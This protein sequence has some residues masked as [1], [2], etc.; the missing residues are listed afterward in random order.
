[1]KTDKEYFDFAK[2]VIQNTEPIDSATKVQSLIETIQWADR[3]YYVEDNPMLSDTEYDLLFAKLKLTEGE[4]PQWQFSYSPSQNVAD[5]LNDDFEK[6]NHLQPM[7]SLDNSYNDEDLRDWNERIKKILGDQKFEFTVEPKFDGASISA[8]ISEHSIE[9]VL[10]RGNGT[11]GDDITRNARQIKSLPQYV[12]Y[13]ENLAQAEVRGEV[14]MKW[15]DFDNYNAYLESEGK[16]PMVNPRNAASGSLRMKDPMELQKRRLSAFMYHVSYFRPEN[17]RPYDTHLGALKWL[18]KLG[19]QTALKYTGQC[20]D[21]EGVIQYCLDFEAKRDDMGFEIDGMVVKVNSL[22][23]QEELGS[24]A[25]HPRWAMAYKFKAKQATTKLERVEYQVG[26][27]GAITPVAKIEPVFVGGVTISSVSLFNEDTI[28]DKD[29]KLGDV[30]VVERSGDVI[31]Y[32]RKSLP[33]LR[34]GAEKEIEFPAA[35]PVCET[36]LIKEDEDVAWR[37]PNY[38]CPAQNEERLIHFVS[39]NAMDIK[40]MGE[41]HV[42][43]FYQMGMIRK[44]EDIYTMDLEVLR[45]EEGYG[46][47]TIENLRTAIEESKNRA[48]NRVLFALGV[49]HV[50]QTTAK[51]IVQQLD[52]SLWEIERWSIEELESIEDIGPKVAKSIYEYF[53][54]ASAK[55]T[56][57]SLERSGV[58]LEIQKQKEISNS[59]LNGKTFLFTGAMQMK[60]AEAEEMAEAKGGKILSG[61]SSKLDY[62][63]VGEK[64]GSKLAKAEKLGT[65]NILTEDEFLELI[66]TNEA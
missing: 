3:K 24:T 17:E 59:A 63:V 58:N 60:R 13:E 21:I 25:H 49:R 40:S 27:T 37:C 33:E 2:A 50:G 31:P 35:C 23:Q 43:K 48:P 39:K 55:D 14:V 57:T 65:V 42:R 52:H 12:S 29:L 64:A 10:T 22:A 26:R 4:N 34:T 54:S 51:N 36:T 53:H 28:R 16:P 18:E 6:V 44:P 30:V 20:A 45:G 66:K 11:T 62:L 32:I 61:V 9:R 41:S 1:M 5:G 19:F 8:W 56:L 7:L 47:K 38:D 15:T 46:D